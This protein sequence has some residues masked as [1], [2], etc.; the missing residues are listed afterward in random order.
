MHA[1]VTAPLPNIYRRSVRK[2]R[3]RCTCTHA[4]LPFFFK[5]DSFY[6]LFLASLDDRTLRKKKERALKWKK[7][8]SKRS[9]RFIHLTPIENTCKTGKGIV[10]RAENVLIHL[11]MCEQK[12]C[13]VTHTD[14][15][16]WLLHPNQSFLI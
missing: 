9:K 12:R 6:V 10:A 15:I 3:V 5:W 2:P 1:F 4:L 11:S 14:K 16:T 13:T 8:C 7:K